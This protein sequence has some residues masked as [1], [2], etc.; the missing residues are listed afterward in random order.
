MIEQEGMV[1]HLFLK[2]DD[3]K[4]DQ[5]SVVAQTAPQSFDIFVWQALTALLVGGSIHV[6]DDEQR[7]DPS[8]LHLLVE[9][10]GITVLEVVPSFLRALLDID[11]TTDLTWSSLKLLVVTGEAL[12]YDL[13]RRW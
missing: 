10:Q 2:I 5:Q 11:E 12:P 3:L 1:N 4:L 6:V 9:R 7:R 13:C 8:A